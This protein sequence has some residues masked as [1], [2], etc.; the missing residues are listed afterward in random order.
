MPPEP[1]SQL[2]FTDSRDHWWDEEYIAL[3]AKRLGL[4]R[5]RRVLDVGSGQGHFARLWAPHLARDFEIVCADREERSLA[6]ARTRGDDLIARRGLAGRFAFVESSAEALPFENDSFDV[7]ICQ[8]LLIHVREPERVLSEMMRVTKRGGTVVAAEPNNFAMAQHAA[9]FGPD[10]EPH[11]VVREL[12]FQ[13]TCVRGKY[14]LGLGWNNLGVHLP[15]LFA[16]LDNVRYF[17]NDRPS[18]SAPPYATAPERAGLQD[19]RSLVARGIYG[20]E[21]EEAKRYFVAGGGDPASFDAEYQAGLERQS[22]VV[23]AMDANEWWELG[24][25]VLM[26]ATGTKR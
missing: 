19:L 13:A 9:A 25:M 11:E 24:A 12:L 17:Q 2:Y 26:I 5:A 3:L 23:N 4:D 14:R 22:R 10:E 21:R 18:F 7:V 15:K 16:G 8:T 1:H 20:W 6:V